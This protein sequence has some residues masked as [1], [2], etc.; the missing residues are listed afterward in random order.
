MKSLGQKTILT[1]GVAVA[2]L[3]MGCSKDASSSGS[4]R[5]YLELPLDAVL[6][7]VGSRE[8]RKA[9]LENQI[10]CRI[11]MIK[12]T[13]R[14]LKDT[15]REFFAAG[16]YVPYFRQFMPKALY[17][18]AAE[19]AGIKP[20]AEDM[21]IVER[22]VVQAYG[23]GVIKSFDGFRK[24]LTPQQ[25]AVLQQRVADDA[26]IF[27]YWRSKAPEAFV[28]TDSEFDAIRKRAEEMN[29]HSEKLLKEQRAKAAEI[30]GRLKNGEDFMNLAEKESVTANEDSA[31]FW[32]NF[33]PKEIP[34]P[35]IAEVVSKMK[36][37]DV[38]KPIELDDAIHIVKLLERNGTPNESVFAPDGET[39][40]LSRIVVRLPV[41]YVVGST[42]EI[43][44]DMRKQKLEPLQKGWLAE[45][46][47]QMPVEYPSG[48]N[49]WTF[50][51][52]KNVPRP[53][54]AEKSVSSSTNSISGK[55]SK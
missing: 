17:V 54:A 31:G 9:D 10:D 48:T 22:E 42:N 28:V 2:A 49:L 50:L 16:M 52:K 38:S 36:P 8:L 18:N 6:M 41:M 39:V 45:L 34:Y 47:S 27:A 43:R 26:L 15:R 37:G 25:F 19:R 53:S 7:K 51:R 5:N 24:H 35:E 13:N 55:K 12:A 1:V 32:G 20:T 3:M 33:S 21:A 46:K 14:N 29:A 23:N 11:A 30:Y 40:S 44:R 4:G